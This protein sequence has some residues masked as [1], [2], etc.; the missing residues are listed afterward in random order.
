MLRLLIS[1]GEVSGDLQGS[2]LIKA[3]KS[4]A[5]KRGIELEILALGGNRMRAAGAELVAN[6]TS[7]GAIGFWE[8]LPFVIPTLRV[9]SLVDEVLKKREPD[10]VVL[11]DYMGPNIRLGNK[12]RKIKSNS[13]II[14]YIAPQEWAWRVADGGTT[15]LI[16]FSDK[17]LA[18]FKS[19]AEFYS[20]RGGKVTWVGHPMLDT[21]TDLPTRKEALNRLGIGID[22]KV[23]LLLPASRS[24]EL[25]YLMPVLTQA[26][27][28][29]QIDDPS[30]YFLVPASLDSFEKPLRKI[31]DFYGVIGEVIP[32]SKTDELKPFLFAAAELALGKSGT[33]NMELALNC[34]PQ[35]VGYKISRITAFILSKLLKF[36]IDYISPVNLLMKERLVPEL[37]QE[38]FNAT[39][40]ADLALPLLGNTS[41]RSEMIK[42]YERFRENLGNKGV[43]KRAA[44]EI[45][46]LAIK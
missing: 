30:L 5:I 46:N 1:T 10:A 39:S 33:I 6:T 16:A 32:A 13:P 19:E 2:L 18:I 22:K 4:E 17:I 12:I 11:I 37:V 44:N 34:V 21:L 31:L 3:L 14:Y 40:I 25:K 23:V 45:I 28:L 35:V 7:I 36:N 15:D 43:T 38:D 41:Y 42:N 8:A 20:D 27:A 9:Q 26:A 29:L 24:Q